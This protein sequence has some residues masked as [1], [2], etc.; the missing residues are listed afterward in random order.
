MEK[1]SIATK[2][3]DKGN[4]S[5]MHGRE[6]PKHNLRVDAYGSV[7]ELNAILGVVRA[8]VK[9]EE[10]QKDILAIQK[11]TFVINTELATTLYDDYK[12]SKEKTTQEH[13]DFLQ[14]RVDEIEG[15]S[16]RLRSI[17][18]NPVQITVAVPDIF[19]ARKHVFKCSLQ[20]L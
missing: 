13:I 8:A 3:G 6:V 17:P 15:L 14:K 5:V 16:V 4:T 12:M 10:L 2:K 11:H 1:F 18:S 19:P 7:D 9:D 20:P